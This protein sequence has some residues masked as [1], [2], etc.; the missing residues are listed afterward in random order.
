[1]RWHLT[2]LV[3]GFPKY[4]WW[5]VFPSV[6]ILIIALGFVLLGDR[7]QDIIGGRAVY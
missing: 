1:M 2:A 7:L 6:T 3:G 4:W 5:A